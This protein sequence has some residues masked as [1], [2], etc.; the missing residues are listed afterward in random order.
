[1]LKKFRRGLHRDPGKSLDV[2]SQVMGAVARFFQIFDRG[3][4]K[5]AT[6]L[7]TDDGEDWEDEEEEDE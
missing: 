3:D 1:M 4:E 2:G 6:V 7:G 5:L